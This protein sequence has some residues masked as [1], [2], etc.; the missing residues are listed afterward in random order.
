MRA[1]LSL[2]LGLALSLSGCVF[3]EPIPEDP[4]LALLPPAAAGRSL[5]ISQDL[6]LQQGSQGYDAVAALQ[7]DAKELSLVVLGPMGNR[8]LSLHWDGQHLI[9]QRDPSLPPD[10]PLR[11]I[12]RDLQYALFPAEA[13]RSLL[14]GG[15]QLVE[16]G[17]AQGGHQRSIRHHDKD[18]MT[19]VYDGP[20][21]F[22]A[23]LTLK[24]KGFGYAITVA[25]A[26]DAP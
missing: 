4:G 16:K 18:V 1:R 14:P 13:V 24:N 26:A 17:L 6:H 2:A 22:A 9:E 5:E 19:V 7:L 20:D 10:L 23:T 3:F 21:P 25:P 11:A 8:M 12:L 15:W